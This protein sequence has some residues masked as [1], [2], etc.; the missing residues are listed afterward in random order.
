MRICIAGPSGTGKTTLANHIRDHYDINFIS[1]SGLKMLKGK[2]EADDK[3]SKIGS[4][5]EL[6]NNS[7]MDPNWG[8]EM[9]Y[10]ILEVR[11]S[12]IKGQDDF[13]I[14]RSP[15]D[16]FTYA[17]MECA[18]NMTHKQ[19]QV[20]LDTCLISLINNYDMMVFIRYVNPKGILEENGSRI[21]NPFFQ[22][23]ADILFN[24]YYLKY[25]NTVIPSLCIDYWNLEG[26]IEAAINFINKI[27]ASKNG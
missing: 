4:H 7:S 5:K 6:I 23:K 26:R 14:D 22:E 25:F 19:S 2:G 16:N 21:T 11:T 20:F 8:I 9:Q 13:I 3:V 10:K 24:H 17:M 18:H 27:N 1:G 12:I 15:L